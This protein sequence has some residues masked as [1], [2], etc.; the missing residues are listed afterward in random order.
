M[1]LAPELDVVSVTVGVLAPESWLCLALSPFAAK[2]AFLPILDQ[3]ALGDLKIGVDQVDQWLG[4]LAIGTAV[5]VQLRPDR[6]TSYIRFS[7]L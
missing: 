6:P 7:I 1:L 4:Q 3:D 2:V 5:P